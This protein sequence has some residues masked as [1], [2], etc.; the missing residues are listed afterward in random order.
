MT[1]LAPS[2][3]PV[4]QEAIQFN[5]P[6]SESS[7]ASIGAIGNY[8]LNVIAP[9]GT[10]WGS[11]LFDSGDGTHPNNSFQSQLGS[12]NPNPPTWVLA[13][14][15]DVTGSRYQTLT[16][17]THIPDLR[18]IMIRAANNG[19][20]AAGTRADGKQNPDGNLAPGTYSADKLASHTH[21]FQTDYI[22][23]TSTGSRGAGNDGDTYGT[24]PV[25]LDNQIKINN[26]GGNETAPKN[27]TINYFIR[28]N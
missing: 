1:D 2:T 20:S 14:G 9:V 21:T 13:D 11:M 19:G 23:N 7:L 28:I 24:N 26:T 22:L 6:V 8:L 18:G 27:V 15:R 25:Q 3:V 4:Q 16:G 10:I 5:N 17:N 12:G